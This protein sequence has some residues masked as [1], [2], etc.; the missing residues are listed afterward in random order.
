MEHIKVIK[1]SKL[2][3]KVGKKCDPGDW[4]TAHFKTFNL[5][6]EKLEDTK[7]YKKG[8]P[9]SFPIGHY[10]VPKCWEIALT[11]LK[12]GERIRMECPAFYAYGGEQ[13]YGH[14]GSVQIPANSDLVFELDV[15]N[16]EDSKEDLDQANA[17]DG[18]G[19]EKLTGVKVKAK[20]KASAEDEAQIKKE[21]K[22]IK[23][24][25]D[26]VDKEK[27]G[28]KKQMVDVKKD[29][30]AIATSEASEE[31]VDAKVDKLMRKE[32]KIIAEKKMV[33]DTKEKLK[34]AEK[35][36]DD[37]KVGSGSK[38]DDDADKLEKKIEDAKKAPK[39]EGGK[40][41]GSLGCFYIAYTSEKGDDGKDLVLEIE[42]KDKYHPKKTGVYNVN[43]QLSMAGLAKDA[44][45]KGGNHKL[46]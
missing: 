3:D 27:D 29:E 35:A 39:E 33:D 18:N 6:E 9:I 17:N 42:Q 13:K 7:N 37:A 23:K 25:K 16:C 41:L 36:V 30:A 28:I 21:E 46:A 43:L 4:V 5:H 2:K 38:D 20:P 45:A 26:V 19:A 40:T 32:E 10:E 12:A 8:K 44:D 34:A 31:A 14:F 1:T 24:L 11:S 22:A 15:L